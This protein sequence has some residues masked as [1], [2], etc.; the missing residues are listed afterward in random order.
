MRL[1]FAPM[2]GITDD[3]FRRLHHRYFPGVDRYYTPFL[4]PGEGRGLAGKDLR[5]VLPENN[6]GLSLVPQLLT[7]SAE[8]FLS[9]AKILEDLGYREVNL[10]LGCPSGTVTAKGKGAGLLYPERREQLR[11]F[12]GEIFDRCPLTISVKLRLGKE[13]PREFPEILSLLSAYPVGLLILHPRV[14]TDLYRRPVRWEWL[15]WARESTRLPLA[16]SG[17]IPTA[18]ALAGVDTRGLEAVMFGRGLVADPALVTKLKGGSG[19]D[20]ETLEAFCG[21]FFQ[22]TAAHLGGARPTMFRM[23][24]IWSWLILLFDGREKLWRQL[25]KCTDLGEYRILVHRIFQ[26]LP[27]RQEPEVTWM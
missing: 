11:A 6:P 15:D 5:Q 27:L 21:E 19:A 2:E 3:I 10:N 1:E 25:R 4:S 20:R 12:L 14:R 18:S 17:G 16:L 8:H 22:E 24:E 9:A 26:E 23:K 13:D 7:A